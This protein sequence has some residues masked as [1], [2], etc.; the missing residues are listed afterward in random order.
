MSNR[1]YSY[2]YD[3][4]NNPNIN[5]CYW[6]G[7]LASDGS[8]YYSK[9]YNNV[10]LQITSSIQDRCILEE[11]IK[12]TEYTGPLFNRTRLGH[13]N[14]TQYYSICKISDISAWV[15]DLAKYW[16]IVSNK[17]YTLKPPNIQNII[18]QLSYIIGTID[19]DGSICQIKPKSIRK[20]KLRLENPYLAF[21]IVGTQDLLC[22][23]KDILYSLEDQNKYKNLKIISSINN[24]S[25]SISYT[26]QRALSILKFLKSINTPYK[27]PRKWDKVI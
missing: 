12:N 22:W 26:H 20:N 7:F 5:N 11:F 18:H 1:K 3:Y 15:N 24:A 10:S 9:K 13:K 21:N 4:F 2:N 17:V 14:Q 23:I 25:Y 19:G 6:A 8:I 16:N 27:L